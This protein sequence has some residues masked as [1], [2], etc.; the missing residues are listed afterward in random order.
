VRG[1]SIAPVGINLVFP[2]SAGRHISSPHLCLCTG[3]PF[4]NG[5]P[6]AMYNSSIG[7]SVSGRLLWCTCVHNVKMLRLT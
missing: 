3:R 6:P 7:K 1:I 4:E 2:Q 5:L